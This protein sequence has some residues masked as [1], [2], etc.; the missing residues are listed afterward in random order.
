MRDVQENLKD[1]LRENL[2]ENI[3]ELQERKSYMHY[4]RL[5]AGGMC[6]LAGTLLAIYVGGWLMLL[7][8]IKETIAAVILGTVSKKMVIV[9]LLKCLLSMTTA[10]AIWCCGYILNRKLAGYEK[11]A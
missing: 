8:P 2:Q 5:M 6:S 10:G 7:Y 1:N 4:A 3:K 9:S 11:R